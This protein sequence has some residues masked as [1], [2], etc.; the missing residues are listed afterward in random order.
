MLFRSVIANLINNAIK[1]SSPKGTVF[2][3]VFF[4]QDDSNFYIRVRN[5]GEGIPKQYLDKIFDKFVQVEDEK[6]KMGKGL[7]LTFCKMAVEAH[8]GKIWVESEAGKGSTFYFT[9]PK[10]T[11]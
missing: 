1:H 3:K 2:V 5:S 6:A 8:G 10:K 4:K 9:I 7:G 11:G